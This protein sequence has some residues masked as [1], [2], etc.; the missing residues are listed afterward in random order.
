MQTNGEWMTEEDGIECERAVEKEQDADT[1]SR[2]PRHTMQC[3]LCADGCTNR[4]L[5]L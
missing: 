3:V 2:T 5:K 1:V 4:D